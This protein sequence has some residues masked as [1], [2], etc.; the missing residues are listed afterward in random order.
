MAA[1]RV[2]RSLVY[3]M[4][5]TATTVEILISIGFW[6]VLFGITIAR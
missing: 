4:V 6:N 5:D 1:S 2:I 3:M